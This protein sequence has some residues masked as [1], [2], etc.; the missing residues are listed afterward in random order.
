MELNLSQRGQEDYALIKR[1]LAGEQ[2]AFGILLSRYK[3]SVN[4]MILKMVHNRDDADDLTIEAFSKAFH[5]LDKY[6][7]DYTFS[8]WLYKIA[9]NN[10]IDFIRRKKL[11]LLSIDVQPEDEGESLSHLL[12]SHHLGPEDHYIKEQRALLMHSILD[13]LNP[14]YRTLVEMRYFDELSYD[15]IAEKMNLPLGTVK[16]SLFRARDLLA[17]VL[18]GIKDRY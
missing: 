1:A 18:A 8:T 14:R 6:Q 17:E 5:H 9:T 16:A 13:K 4:Y 2:K 10:T 3:D 7:P 11:K 12:P 15:E